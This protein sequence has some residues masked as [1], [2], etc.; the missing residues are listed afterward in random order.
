MKYSLGPVI[1][2]ILE[3]KYNTQS[4]VP[5]RWSPN[6]YVNDEEFYY[7]YIQEI[8]DIQLLLFHMPFSWK[9]KWPFPWN[10]NLYN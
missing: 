3:F 7:G 8:I 6:H 2:Y 4:Q 1:P 5:F 10:K 9:K